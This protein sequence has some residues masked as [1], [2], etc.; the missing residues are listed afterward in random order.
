ML[1]VQPRPATGRSCT[2]GSE[3]HWSPAQRV[4]PHERGRKVWPGN[5]R[6]RRM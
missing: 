2:S 4:K 1:V 3:R 6:V 5:A